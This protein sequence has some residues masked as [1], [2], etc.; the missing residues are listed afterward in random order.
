[1]NMTRVACLVD[2]SGNRKSIEGS[3]I[4]I[5]LGGGRVLHV[6]LDTPQW[7]EQ[8]DGVSIMCDMEPRQ[9][10]DIITHNDYLV[11]RPGASNTM[12]VTIERQQLPEPRVI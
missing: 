7:G 1:M 6:G 3:S 12:Q 9:K 4:E 5:H 10:G 2:L 8:R 11:I